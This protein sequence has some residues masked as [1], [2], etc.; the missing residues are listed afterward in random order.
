MTAD[1]E[2]PDKTTDKKG[3]LKAA[4]LYRSAAVDESDEMMNI[5]GNGMEPLYSD[6]D[7]VLVKYC[8]TIAEGEVGAYDY[9]DMGLIIRYKGK[10]GLRRLNPDCDDKILSEESAV[11]IGKVLCKIT[12]DMIPTPKEREDYIRLIGLNGL[13]EKAIDP[14]R[15]KAS[16]T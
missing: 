3:P 13:E 4:L 8:D 15:D 11:V 1:I 14:G 16:K 2:N 5:K 6:G 9:P 7:R 12:P 10:D